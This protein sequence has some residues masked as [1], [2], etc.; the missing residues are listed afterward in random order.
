[1]LTKE[2]TALLVIDIQGNLAKAMDEQEMLYK[3][4]RIMIQS[5]QILGLPIIV[6]EQLPDKLGPTIPEIAELLPDAAPVVKSAFSCCGEPAFM[7]Q[8]NA[9]TQS[10]ILV[11]GIEAHICVYQTT[12]ELIQNG[13]EANVVTDCIGSRQNANKVAG[14]DKMKDAGAKLTASEIAIFELMKVAQGDAFRQIVRL[15]K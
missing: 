7:T 4:T 10:Q 9:L 8:L 3:N 13:Y 11:T 12:V 2:N 14:I 6:T 15:L 5:A 1:M